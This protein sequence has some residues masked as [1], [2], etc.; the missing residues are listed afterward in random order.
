MHY[1]AHCLHDGTV[2]AAYPVRKP[3]PKTIKQE[4]LRID[5]DGVCREWAGSG[6]ELSDVKNENRTRF[7]DIIATRLNTRRAIR[8]M[9]CPYLFKLQKDMDHVRN[10][11]DHIQRSLKGQSNVVS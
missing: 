2:I 11:L 6:K 1:S 8:E 7:Q 9:V 4:K 3:T 10:Q 5:E